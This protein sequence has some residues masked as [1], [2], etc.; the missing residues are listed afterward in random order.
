MKIFVNILTFAILLYTTNVFAID[1]DKKCKVSDYKIEFSKIEQPAYTIHVRCEF[2]VNFEQILNS[3]TRFEMEFGG[4]EDYSIDSVVFTS[5][6]SVNYN[7]NRKQKKLQIYSTKE[8]YSHVI[9]EYDYL[10]I[11]S[12]FIYRNVCEMWETSFSEYYYPY[13]WGEKSLF[14]ITIKVPDEYS[15]IGAYYFTDIKNETNI[16]TYHYTTK[17]PV[18][19]HSCVFAILPDSTY[20]HTEY[21]TN[22]FPVDFYLLKDINVPNSRI[23]ELL[24]LTTASIDF[25]SKYL[26]SYS[27][28]HLGIENKMSYIFH[29]NDF[30]N[31]ND[32]N[33]IIASQNKF[34]EKSHILPLVHEIGHRW[35]GEWTLLIKDGNYGAYFIK[36][37]LNEY[38]SFLFAK[39]YYGQNFFDN[40]IDSCQ[41]QYNIIKNTEKDKPLYEMKF[42]SNNTV[43]YNKGSL[44]INEIVKK[45]G[46]E[47]WLSFMKIF[48]LKYAGCPNLNYEKFIALL[49]EENE[50]CAILLDE[51]VK[52]NIK[53]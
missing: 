30:S 27:N 40:L 43:V 17:Y 45:M 46:D 3:D 39:K 2:D 29:K 51:L 42:N 28:E 18:V 14:D 12:A 6:P 8:N 21:N 41:N 52:D 53:L 48:Y 9:M 26:T 37:S 44:I 38:L 5:Y 24:N 13:V 7:Y 15:V 32:L 11:N 49:K 25:F 31:R 47:N 33:F 19:S 50:D 22:D 10:A 35:F 20:S 1:T 16:K 23:T 34:A 4:N 36:E